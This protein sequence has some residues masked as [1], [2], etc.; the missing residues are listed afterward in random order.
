MG[1]SH[2]C[3]HTQLFEAA[4][5]LL[6]LALATEKYEERKK[7]KSFFKIPLKEVLVKKDLCPGNYLVDL[8]ANFKKLQLYPPTFSLL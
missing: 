7:K 6:E 2:R 8:G 3:R 1:P 5:P 4:P